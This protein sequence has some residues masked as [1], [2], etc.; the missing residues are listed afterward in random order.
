MSTLASTQPIQGRIARAWSGRGRWPLASAIGAGIATALVL[1]PLIFLVVQAL[2]SGWGEAER[3]LV[4][5]LTAVLLWNTVRLTIACTL[6]R[7]S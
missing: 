7:T 6:S 2:Q 3:L 1:L 5:H 4:R